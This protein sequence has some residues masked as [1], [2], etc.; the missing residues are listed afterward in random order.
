[1]LCIFLSSCGVDAQARRLRVRTRPYH[2]DSEEEIIDEESEL[3]E[4]YDERPQSANEYF[5]SVSSND[6]YNGV[7]GQPT[8]PIPRS[9]ASYTQSKSST[10]SPR[11]KDTQT[12]APPV[13]TIRNYSKVNDDGSF[14]FGYEA[15]DGSFKEETRGTDCVVRGKYGYID[16]DGNKREFTY[17]S[18]NPC[19]PNH[20][21]E[22]EE[23][24][25]SEENLDE[26]ENVP[27]N[28]PS[29]P[30]RPVT[31]RTTHAPTT[32]FQNQYS[33]SSA[34]ASYQ[35][36]AEDEQPEPIQLLQPQSQ[37]QRA[38]VR[39]Q[40]SQHQLQSIAPGEV[41]IRQRPRLTVA[42]TTPIPISYKTPTRTAHPVS[43]TP[44][45]T[46]RIPQQSLQTQLPATTYRPNVQYVTQKAAAITYSPTPTSLSVE[47]LTKSTYA[48]DRKPIDFAVEFQKFQQ[49][50]SVLQ[51][52][53]TTPR[54]LASQQPFKP[55]PIQ[56]S[57]ISSPTSNPIYQSQLVFD[58]KTGQYDSALFQQLPQSDGDLILNNRHQPYQHQP[59]F[60]LPQSLVSIEQLE[61]RNQQPI[62]RRPAAPVNIQAPRIPLQYPN[63]FSQQVYQKDQ[64]N[65]QVLNSQQL[66]AQ[67][68]ELQLQ[69]LHKDRIEA[70]NRKP[71]PTG[72]SQPQHRFQNQPQPIRQELLPQQQSPQ[73]F[74]FVQQPGQSTGQIDAF[75]RGHNLDFN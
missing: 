36:S 21:D 11:T 20:P 2:S 45:P 9:R 13:Q 32:V 10:S 69:Q 7:Y 55:S 38:T 3:T 51:Q 26:P 8:T 44:R 40:L 41:T 39:P 35:E 1:M 28:Y 27:Q 52:Q 75:L 19:D 24:D 64:E 57:Q 16:P 70:A 63:H 66:Y 22:N 62:Y 56:Q 25:R 50:H 60:N 6:D 47:P 17:V 30:I 73:G 46:Y 58:P 65:S 23:S 74:Y 14:T 29:R 42:N 34:A 4:E 67:Q 61:Q 72:H 49:E 31:S 43:I 54:N 15:A 59:Q 53:S 48:N 71:I 5:K 33:S 68:Q 37:Q 12:K 18:G